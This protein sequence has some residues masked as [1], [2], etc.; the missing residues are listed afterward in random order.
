MSIR[1]ACPALLLGLVLAW[2]TRAAEDAARREWMVDGVTREAIVHLPA[3]ATTNDGPLVFVFHG[4]GGSMANARRSFRID[5]LW[6]EAI[7]VYPQGLKT[8]G[9]LTDPEGKRA[10]WQ[11]EPGDQADRD[12]KF[13]DAM[14]ESFATEGTADTNRV[15]ST[16]HSNGGAFTY[17]L[18]ATR[19]ERLR[20][21]APSAAVASVDY[22]R[23]PESKPVLHIAGERDELVKFAWQERMIAVLLR[24]N[25]CGEGRL[26]N[27]APGCTMYRSAV[28]ASVVTFIHPGAHGFPDAGRAHIVKFFKEIDAR[29]AMTPAGGDQ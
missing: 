13:F 10:G 5:E 3:S 24:I 18:W 14:L 4:H 8:P 21:V 28:N 16:G 22:F 1:R 2:T 9:R 7:V 25:R 11:R 27:D 23:D 20:A 15:Y 6:P 29:P 26:W 17:L 12:L 19:G